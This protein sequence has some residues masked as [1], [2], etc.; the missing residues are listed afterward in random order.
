MVEM[1]GRKVLVLLAPGYEELEAVAVIDVLRRAG[2][3]VTVAGLVTGPVPSARGVKIVP[4]RYID[5]VTGQDYDLVVLPGGIE[6]T[7]NLSRDERVIGILRDQLA[8]GRLVGAIC[9]APATVLE[10]H[11]MTRGRV[12]TC[13]P[14][15]QD[16]IEQ[17]ELSSE[18]VVQD[19]SLVTSQ[20][21]GT[22]VEFAL[23]LVEL[24]AGKEKML[25]VNKGL[26]ARIQ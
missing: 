22:A 9:A 7:E 15:C 17:A 21:P 20:A 25:E 11:G 3:D 16:A 8:S 12:I 14:V 26:L 6:G 5:E 24:L 23:R 18:R 1:S 4:D 13:H 2:I 19:G 10:R